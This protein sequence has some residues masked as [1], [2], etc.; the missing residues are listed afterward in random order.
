MKF[1]IQIKDE[2]VD[3]NFPEDNHRFITFH[4]T[5]HIIMN[6]KDERI[7][8]LINMPFKLISDLKKHQKSQFNCKVNSL[9]D[10]PQF[11]CNK[12]SHSKECYNYLKSNIHNKLE[13]FYNMIKAGMANDHLSPRHI[14]Y[15]HTK[16]NNKRFILILDKNGLNIIGEYREYPD[17]QNSY[18][19]VKT[20][21]RGS[22]PHANKLNLSFNRHINDSRFRVY[23]SIQKWKLKTRKYHQPLFYTPE[24]WMWA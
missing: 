20:C 23:N 14:L 8:D 2:T 3:V 1:N 11:T 18:I 13:K 5:K 9:S 19:K 10:E 15:Y 21:Y 4:I 17:N 22:I 12:C 7:S 16:K 24:N 6:H